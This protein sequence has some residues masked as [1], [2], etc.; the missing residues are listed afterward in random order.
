MTVRVSTLV[1]GLALLAASTPAVAQNRTTTP[2]AAPAPAAQPSA[3]AP[4]AAPAAP[5]KP[6][7]LVNIRI[8]FTI[9]ESRNGV[10][11]TKRTVSLIAAD[12]E[13]GSVRSEPSA[14]AVPGVLQLNVDARPTIATADKIRLSFSL[15]YSNPG[16]VSSDSPR[17]TVTTTNL[18]E[19]LSVIVEDGKPLLV[20]QSA[21][22]TSDRKVTVEVN[23][24]ILR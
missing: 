16:A 4:K 9:T 10:E 21:D 23:A 11:P 15:Q 2:A 13:M 3:P 8:E 24:A 17:G 20:A 5:K 19:S 7:Q 6:G 22:P 18:R 1:I 12:G 14:L